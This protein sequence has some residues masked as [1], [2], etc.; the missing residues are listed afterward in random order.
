[1]S[2][3]SADV[4][5]DAKKRVSNVVSDRLKDGFYGYLVTTVALSNW[6]NIFILLK[7]KKPIEDTL[8]NMTS[9]PDFIYDYFLWPLV[10]GTLAAFL[11][12]WVVVVYVRMVAKARSHIKSA[13]RAADA[14]TD[15]RLSKKELKAQLQHNQKLNLAELLETQRK[16]SK[17]L[18]A[19]LANDK[20]TKE[21]FDKFIK[22]L[23]E[24]FVKAPP[25]KKRRRL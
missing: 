4:R 7:S 20:A 24:V 13:E 21:H 6:Q 25:N 23:D 11:M 12:P 9:S 10:F 22:R 14:A 8:L 19:E 5:E 3:N 2:E 15:V 16:E 1:M 18:K 17:T